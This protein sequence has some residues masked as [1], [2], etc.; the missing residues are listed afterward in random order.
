[1]DAKVCIIFLSPLF[2]PI[3]IIFYFTICVVL[4]YDTDTTLTHAIQS[5]LFYKI[6]ICI[7]ISLLGLLS[8]SVSVL[9]DQEY[10]YILM[11]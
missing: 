5:L 8:E 10:D 2:I 4:V 6:I 9:Y 7:Y 11:T 1:M 3:N